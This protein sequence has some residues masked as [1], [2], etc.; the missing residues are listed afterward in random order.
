MAGLM[1]DFG[2]FT[3]A[4]VRAIP[5][6]FA[7]SAQRR[8]GGELDVSKAQREHELYIGVL[9]HE[10]GLRVLELPA[11]ESLPDCA[12]VGDAAVVCGD[13]ALIARPGA[14]ARR[15][16]NRALH[17]LIEGER[18]EQDSPP[19]QIRRLVPSHRID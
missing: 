3:H 9:K 10:L 8:S 5:D 4:V 11:D 14:A 6:S 18:V 2:N 15:K 17:Y 7:K 12:L 16:E 19:G 13:T 1:T